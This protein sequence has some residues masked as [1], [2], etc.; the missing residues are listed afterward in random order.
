MSWRHLEAFGERYACVS[1]KT[2]GPPERGHCP[3]DLSRQSFL[4]DLSGEGGKG[5]EQKPQ[6]VYTGCG[7]GGGHMRNSG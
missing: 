5:S 4:G 3:Q 7:W 6:G 1:K 2:L